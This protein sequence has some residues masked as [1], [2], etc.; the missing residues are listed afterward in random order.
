MRNFHQVEIQKHLLLAQALVLKAMQKL[1]MSGSVYEDVDNDPLADC[2]MSA[3]NLSQEIG[4]WIVTEENP[5]ADYILSHNVVVGINPDYVTAVI[6]RELERVAA[7][8]VLE[9]H[10][11]QV[12]FA[13]A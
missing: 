12:P 13:Y 3:M 2:Y 5:Y 7:E 11:T 8:E 10:T 1:E 4:Q 6:Q 9:A